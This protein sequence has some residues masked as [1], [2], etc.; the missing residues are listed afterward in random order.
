M[1]LRRSNDRSDRQSPDQGLAGAKIT[2][3]TGHLATVKVR[4]P[5]V[6]TK[7]GVGLGLGNSAVTPAS[8][9]GGSNS[10]GTSGTTSTGGG[11]TPQGGG[12]QAPASA[13]NPG[14]Q[15]GQVGG[16]SAGLIWPY[17]KNPHGDER[18]GYQNPNEN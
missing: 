12:A 1:V 8:S 17:S 3:N 16:N 14:R 18:G 10:P 11:V 4:V 6:A 5:D 9:N 7:V 15:A 2:V 13:G